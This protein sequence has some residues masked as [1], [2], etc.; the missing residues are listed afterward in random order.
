M[1]FLPIVYKSV[2]PTKLTDWWKYTPEKK[3][4]DQSLNKYTLKMHLSTILVDDS[5]YLDN[6]F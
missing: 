2:S 6:L 5:N 4:V 1:I 3:N